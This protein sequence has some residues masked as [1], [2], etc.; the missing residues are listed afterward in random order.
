MQFLR[1]SEVPSSHTFLGL[2]ARRVH[3]SFPMHCH[4]SPSCQLSKSHGQGPEAR[5]EVRYIYNKNNHIRTFP[6]RISA[7]SVSNSSWRSS[8]DFS[9]YQRVCQNPWQVRF[10]KMKS[11]VG[12]ERG[13]FDI[14]PYET[15]CAL[16]P[17][18]RAMK[19]VALP[20]TQLRPR[21]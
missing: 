14:A 8:R 10:L 2:S 19:V 18:S 4:H 17:S 1:S 12:S 13:S 3:E 16:S 5:C 11:D 20:L 21:R 6:S 7:V 15:R 9:L